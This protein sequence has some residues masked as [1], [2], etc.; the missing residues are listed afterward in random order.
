MITDGHRSSLT[1]PT[2]LSLSNTPLPHP[3][4]PPVGSLSYA[5]GAQLRPDV[6]EWIE[7]A[8]EFITLRGGLL[9]DD[10][11]LDSV[12]EEDDQYEE[13][14]DEGDDTGTEGALSGQDTSDAEGN[15]V[16]EDPDGVRSPE[17]SIRHSSPTSTIHSGS[18][19]GSAPPEGMRRRSSGKRKTPQPGLSSLPPN[20][21][22]PLKLIAD[23]GYSASKSPKSANSASRG[24]SL[25]PPDTSMA[26]GSPRVMSP[27]A[28]GDHADEYE[29]SVL[30]S[31]KPVGEGEGEA[32]GALAPGYFTARKGSVNDPSHLAPAR[33]PVSH[34]LMRG[35]VTPKEVESL[36]Q[37]WVPAL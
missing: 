21:A 22:V 23:L 12:G 4:A 35:I 1:E 7:R 2:R 25:G 30:R 28:S 19:E 11:L 9:D 10:A 14:G 5:A 20:P 8:R 18:R 26:S 6:Q 34:I 37:T 16:I 17:S 31:R 27:T 33:H 13:D 3:G 32:Y 29:G 24:D 36:F 15:I